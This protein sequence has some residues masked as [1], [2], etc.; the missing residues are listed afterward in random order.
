MP[1]NFTTDTEDDEEEVWAL[2]VEWGK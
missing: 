2:R 1:V